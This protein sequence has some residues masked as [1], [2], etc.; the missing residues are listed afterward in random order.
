MC[1][2]HIP[3]KKHGG[4]KDVPRFNKCL[5]IYRSVLSLQNIR[6]SIYRSV[7]SVQNIRCSICQLKSYC[8]IASCYMLHIKRGLN[9]ILLVLIS[10]SVTDNWVMPF[11]KRVAKDGRSINLQ[12][13]L[14][15]KFTHHPLMWFSWHVNFC[16]TFSLL[17]DFHHISLYIVEDV[18]WKIREYNLWWEVLKWNSG[19]LPTGT[20]LCKRLTTDQTTNQYG[21]ETFK[22]NFI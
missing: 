16:Q 3:L 4:C 18:T 17:M 13:S 10:N 2:V 6:C 14:P 21:R 5:R 11:L 8:I 7:L 1:H 20:T 12:A 9:T 15:M 19:K 22:K